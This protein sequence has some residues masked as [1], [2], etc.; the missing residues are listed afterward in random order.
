MFHPTCILEDSKRVLFTDD[1]GNEVCVHHVYGIA[2]I[3]R[4]SVVSQRVGQ[5]RLGGCYLQ[6]RSFYLFI[7]ILFFESVKFA[8]IVSFTSWLC[9]RVSDMWS[10][11]ELLGYTDV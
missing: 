1:I 8:R 6:N 9:V 5:S 3:G 10:L 7:L 11:E 2:S 4:Y